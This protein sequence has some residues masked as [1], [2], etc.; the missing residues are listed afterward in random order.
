MAYRHHCRREWVITTNANGTVN[1]NRELQPEVECFLLWRILSTFC[2]LSQVLNAKKRA[3]QLIDVCESALKT[4]TL[5]S[6]LIPGSLS[7]SSLVVEERD[8]GC[9][10]SRDYAVTTILQEGW[11]FKAVLSSW[12]NYQPG[13]QRD[14]SS[15]VQNGTAFLYGKIMLKVKQAICIEHLF[16]FCTTSW[17]EHL[18]FN[19]L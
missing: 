19:K 15:L 18:L 17:H 8:P 16:L 7:F 1:H 5:P 11:V 3:F 13:D 9:G 10:W 2:T 12:T 14:K 4:R 6:T